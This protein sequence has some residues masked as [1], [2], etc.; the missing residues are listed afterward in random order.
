MLLRR[1][2]HKTVAQL[3][4]GLF[5]M[6]KEGGAMQH[7]AW[8][9]R[10]EAMCRHPVAKIH[11]A[12]TP[13]TDWSP[14][15]SRSGV[16]GPSLCYFMSWVGMRRAFQEPIIIHEIVEDFAIPML[17]AMLGDI[18]NLATI[19]TDCSLMGW[20]VHRRRRYTILSH[21]TKTTGETRSLEAYFKSLPR[22]S[23]ST[24]EEYLLATP[25]EL[26]AALAWARGRP[27]SG[28]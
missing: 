6:I 15:G 19:V 18:Y 13:C 23:N 12:G 28:L 27:T 14:F 25:C 3:D 20:A 16:T 10:H 11:V 21:K 8:C 1:I 7:M 5:R 22:D 24:F 26:E 9:Y 2:K 17:E 4:M